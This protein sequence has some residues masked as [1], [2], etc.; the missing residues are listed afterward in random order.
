MLSFLRKRL[1]SKD[2]N[3]EH[4]QQVKSIQNQ[5]FKFLS[6]YLFILFLFKKDDQIKRTKSTN[7]L[8]I[9]NNENKKMKK[10]KKKQRSSL[11][12]DQIVN[13][14]NISTINKSYSDVDYF[15]MMPGALSQSINHDKTSTN[16]SKNYF[17]LFYIFFFVI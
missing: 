12:I 2:R 17:F 5:V 8:D 16:D 7:E 6:N 13:D 1:P 10:N 3:N 15:P 14:S 9:Q 11:N 4:L